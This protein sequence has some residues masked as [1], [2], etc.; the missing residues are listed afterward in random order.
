MRRSQ[1]ASLMLGGGERVVP[2]FNR[3]M[4][5]VLKVIADG[6]EHKMAGIVSAVSNELGLTD[7]ER[8]KPMPSKGKTRITYVYHRVSWAKTNLE[9]AG[10]LKM[11]GWGRVKITQRGLDVLKDSPNEISRK[12]LRQFDSYREWEGTFKSRGNNS[13]EEPDA[14]S[15]ETPNEIILRGVD[16]LRKDL[17]ADL[18]DKIQKMHPR[19]F[20]ELARQLL[21]Q[22]KYGDTAEK[23]KRSRDGGIDGIVYEDELGLSKIYI[24]CKRYKDTVQVDEV[25]SFMGTLHTTNTKKGIFITTSGFTQSAEECVESLKT[26]AAVVLIDGPKLA[27]LMEKNGVGVTEEA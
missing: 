2:P 17:H 9:R 27:D 3:F 4:L 18:L 14:D 22:M 10:L 5:P 8:D 12:D 21:I 23:T 15:T 20:E 1:T 26:D 6:Q 24:Q 25:R 19:G 11:P 13:D 7:E 16:Q